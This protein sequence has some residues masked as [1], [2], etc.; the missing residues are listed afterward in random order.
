ME[1]QAYM[2][3]TESVFSIGGFVYLKL[4]TYKQTTV[5][6]QH[7]HKPNP[8]NY[9]P[10]LESKMFSMSRSWNFAEMLPLQLCFLCLPILF[11]S[12]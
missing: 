11:G 6:G 12:S 2:H 10:K 1:H 3:R 8:K 9:G 7:F 5:R 4:Q